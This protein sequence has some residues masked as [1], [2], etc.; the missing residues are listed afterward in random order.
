MGYTYN[1]GCSVTLILTH[2]HQGRTGF[3]GYTRLNDDPDGD[4]VALMQGQAPPRLARF[5]ATDY[6]QL[7]DL[8]PDGS[9]TNEERRERVHEKFVENSAKARR[10]LRNVVALVLFVVISSMLAV[11]LYQRHQVVNGHPATTVLAKPLDPHTKFSNGSHTFKRSTLVISLDG[12]HPHYLSDSRTPRLHK[13]VKTG[14]ATPYMRPSFPTQTFPNHW[15]LI[16]GNYPINHGIVGNTFLDPEIGLD[17][18]NVNPEKSRDR[19][20]WG[21]EPLWITAKQHGVKSAVHMWPGSEAEWGDQYPDEY[22][23]YDGNEPL[24]KKADKILGWL[25]SEDMPQLM[26]AYVPN[27]DAVGHASGIFGPQLMAECLSVDQFI[28]TILDGLSHRNLTDI[29]NLVVLSDHGMAPTDDTHMVFLDDIVSNWDNVTSNRGW[30]LAGLRF[31]DDE[32][33]GTAIKSAK[34]AAKK[35]AAGYKVFGSDRMPPSW[36]FTT[37]ELEDAHGHK[38]GFGKYIQRLAPMYIVPEPTYSLVTHDDWDDMGHHYNLAGVHGYDPSSSLMRALFLA[39]GP[40]FPAGRYYTFD[41]ID[42]YSAVC[43]SLGFPESPSSDGNFT[44]VPLMGKIP[45]E[46]YPPTSAGITDFFKGSSFDDFF[47]KHS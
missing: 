17:F 34:S 7:E 21:G 5:G 26:L 3:M 37:S 4:S 38:S 32:E 30:P 41:N 40:A 13:L 14:F 45:V 22:S 2:V 47:D 25:D 33:V 35:G 43:R 20:F 11:G 44:G 23:E 6:V 1:I 19:R 12:M 39:Q 46:G 16:T 8:D 27:I 29:V 18:V 24:D 15:T 10:M 36:H 9:T 42:V 31:R 28:G